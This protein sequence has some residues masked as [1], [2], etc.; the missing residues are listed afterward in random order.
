[1]NGPNDDRASRRRLDAGTLTWR[2]PVLMLFA[3]SICAVAPQAL[4]A[5]IFALGSSPTPWLDAAPW[6]HARNAAPRSGGG[7]RMHRHTKGP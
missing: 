2:G 4:V 1:M 5:V 3:R 7:D 6:R